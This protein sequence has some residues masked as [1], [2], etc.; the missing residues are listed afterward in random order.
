M[1]TIKVTGL[2][3]EIF[4]MFQSNTHLKMLSLQYKMLEQCCITHIVHYIVVNSIVQCCY[5]QLQTR[6]RF[7]NIEQHY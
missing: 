4:Q 7:N 2:G 6:F 1:F 5:T 3:Q